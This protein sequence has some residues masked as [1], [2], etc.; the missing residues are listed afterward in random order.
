[1]DAVFRGL[2]LLGALSSLGASYRTPNFVVEAPSAEFAKQVGDAAEVYRHELAIDWIGKPLP[3]K[4]KYPCPIKVQVGKMGAGGKTTF[5][6]QSG[7]VYGWNMEIQGSEQRILDSVLP[8]EI[9]H[10]IFASHFRRPLPRWADE[11]AASLIEHE[12]ERNQLRQIHRRV[13]GTR[14]KIPL[15][16]LLEMKQYPQDQQDVLT[17]YAE[18]HSLADFLI[19]KSGKL[20]YMRLM[21]LAHDRGWESSLKS[22][23]SFRSLESLENEWEQWVS[24][25][26]PKLSIPEGSQVAGTTRTPPETTIR[27]Q[28]PET[29][30]VADGN[31]KLGTPLNLASNEGSDKSKPRDVATSA[32]SRSRDELREPLLTVSRQTTDAAKIIQE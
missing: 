2:L 10:T 20:E 4:W 17:L 19:Q 28:S 31:I 16:T 7:E 32:S 6:F 26:S 5:N 11:G 27:G 15:K 21:S 23:Y 18:G 29:G 22:L 8:H 30:K 9:N 25:G 3:G 12:S 24:D 13:L 14:R 1:M